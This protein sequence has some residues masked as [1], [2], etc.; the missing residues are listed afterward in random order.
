MA[1]YF[2][3]IKTFGRSGGSSA[4][5]A[6]AYRAGERRQLDRD[7]EFLRGR[8][9]ERIVVSDPYLSRHALN[10]YRR[11][12][13]RG[14]RPARRTLTSVVRVLE[15]DFVNLVANGATRPMQRLEDQRYPAGARKNWLAGSGVSG[16]ASSHG[17]EELVRRSPADGP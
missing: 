1:V 13:H 8:K 7:F 3:N 6:A 14:K 12:A 5:S 15:V 10:V 9:V 17:P 11:P 4:V 16:F 2:L